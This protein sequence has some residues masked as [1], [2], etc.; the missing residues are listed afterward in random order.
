MSEQSVAIPPTTSAPSAPAT[1]SSTPR[2]T[3]HSPPQSESYD[4][5]HTVSNEVT[6]F[7]VES[8]NCCTVPL[9]IRLSTAK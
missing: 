9:D 5:A 4:P 6:W 3:T 2:G 8:I 1:H 7:R